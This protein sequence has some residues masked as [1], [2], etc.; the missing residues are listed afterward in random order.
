M[1][2]ALKF[3]FGTFFL[4]IISIPPL[5][6]AVKGLYCRVILGDKI[7]LISGCKLVA[8]YE[9]F[10]G[11]VAVYV[12]VGLLLFARSTMGMTS[13]ESDNTKN[14][15]SFSA[16][17]DSQPFFMEND[18]V[19]EPR[20]TETLEES[21]WSKYRRLRKTI[22]NMPKY[23]LWRKEVFKKHG[24]RCVVCGSKRSIQIDHRKSFH[25]IIRDHTIT[26]IDEAYECDALWDVDNGNPL[27]KSCH[28]KT[29]HSINYRKLS[30]GEK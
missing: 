28:D 2:Q 10:I 11:L 5:L 27:C 4:Y 17:N 25:S 20:L 24:E 23:S 1:K 18:R 22:E 14:L 3:I 26:N 12:L 8:G 30:A 13:V 19:Y 15:I 29:T 7:P 6:E 16:G 21:K 9:I